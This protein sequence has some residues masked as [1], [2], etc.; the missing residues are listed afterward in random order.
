MKLNSSKE[1]LEAG[2]NPRG[3]C[4]STYNFVNIAIVR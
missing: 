3:K 2:E 1:T 4:V